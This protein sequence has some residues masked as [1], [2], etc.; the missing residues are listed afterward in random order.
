MEEKRVYIEDDMHHQFE[1]VDKWPQHYEIWNIPN[2][3]IPGYVPF[4]QL[5]NYQSFPGGKSVNIHTLKA[6][7]TDAYKEIM[8]AASGSCSFT[9]EDMKRYLNRCKGKKKVSSWDIKYIPLVE[10]AVEEIERI[11]EEEREKCC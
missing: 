2:D 5:D 6:Y 1:I 10:R 11:V 8:I 4:C 7:K 9:L 3:T